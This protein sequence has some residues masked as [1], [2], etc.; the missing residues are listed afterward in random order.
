VVCAP[1]SSGKTFIS[2]YV[3]Q[4]VLR[5]QESAAAAT[6]AAAAAAAA[7]ATTGRSSGLAAVSN[8]SKQKHNT[9]RG[10]CTGKRDM[11]IDSVVL[12]Q[13]SLGAA[14]RAGVVVIVLPTKALVN[15]LAAQVGHLSLFC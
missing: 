2:S 9:K 8:N 12:P 11:S 4:Q 5:P 14:G 15:Q 3:I 7:K 6:A 1:T 13:A 10:Q